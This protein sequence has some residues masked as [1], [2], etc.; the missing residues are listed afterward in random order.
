MNTE[1]GT[2]SKWN[3]EK[4]FGFITPS[5]GG[6]SVFFHINDYSKKHNRPIA[7][8]EVEY[9]VSIDQKGREGAIGVNP[10]N[11]HKKITLASKQQKVACIIFVIFSVTLA[12]LYSL[13]FIPI[14][15][16]IFYSIMSLLTLCMYAKDKSAALKENW[17]TS[18]RTL[19]ILSLLGGWPGAILAQSFLR[20]KSKKIRFRIIFWVTA[21]S[22]CGV[23][24]WSVSSDG[25]LWLT[26]ILDKIKLG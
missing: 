24:G 19:H 13:K 22:N 21:I 15:V 9:F 12:V 10:L 17:R 5:T 6:K 1:I 14:S 26:A 16:I 8:L 7:G 4:G 23:L 20:H 25:N 3:E 11:G 18:E 2:I